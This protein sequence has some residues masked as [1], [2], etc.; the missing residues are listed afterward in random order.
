MPNLFAFQCSYTTCTTFLRDAPFAIAQHTLS[1]TPHD[2]NNFNSTFP[3]YLS[4]R[5]G[6]HKIHKIRFNSYCPFTFKPLQ[7]IL[8]T[9]GKR[10]PFIYFNNATS[11]KNDTDSSMI[12]I[13]SQ[14]DENFKLRNYNSAIRH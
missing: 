1:R 2:H 9:T 10:M 8:N 5:C 13:I 7:C 3:S 14:T 11:N 12:I 6:K 4:D